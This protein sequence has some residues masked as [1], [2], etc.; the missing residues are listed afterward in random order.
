MTKMTKH[1]VKIYAW[2]Y[3]NNIQKYTNMHISAHAFQKCIG[4][5]PQTPR[6]SA[7]GLTIISHDLSSIFSNERWQP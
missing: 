1:F 2:N 6:S 3:F 4:I 5:M 7:S